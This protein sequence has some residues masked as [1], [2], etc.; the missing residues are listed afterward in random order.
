MFEW[1]LIA[2]VIAAIFYAGDLPK[3]K[4]FLSDKFKMLEAKAMEKKAE[5]EAKTT[6]NKSK[7]SA[8]KSDDS[9]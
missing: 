4:A 7:D 1:I 3:I 8:K 5:L 2:L 9:K 6:K